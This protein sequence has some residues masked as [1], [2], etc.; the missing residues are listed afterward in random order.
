MT[1]PLRSAGPIRLAAAEASHAGGHLWL[2]VALELAV[3]AGL[4]AVVAARDVRRRRQAGP[5]TLLVTGGAVGF[6]TLARHG[7]VRDL[8]RHRGPVRRPVRTHSGTIAISHREL[9][10]RPDSY[11]RRHGGRTLVIP[12]NDIRWAEARPRV[13]GLGSLLILGFPDGS[14]IRFVAWGKAQ[15][16]KGALRAAGVVVSR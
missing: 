7:A 10:W 11:S 15:K 13:F 3:V 4:V 5:G 16:L 8:T 1:L 2:S 14:Q 12:L 9:S 6:A